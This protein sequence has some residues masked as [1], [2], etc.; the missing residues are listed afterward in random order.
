[1]GGDAT[2]CSNACVRKLGGR[3]VFIDSKRKAVYAITDQ[4][5]ASEF[6]GKKVR[7]AGTLS[8]DKKTVELL[9]IAEVSER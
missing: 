8:A 7:V 2:S 6:A 4:S 5:R 1:M 9:Q 3:Y